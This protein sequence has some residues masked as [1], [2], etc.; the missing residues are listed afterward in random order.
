MHQLTWKLCALSSWAPHSSPLRH[1]WCWLRSHTWLIPSPATGYPRKPP[2]REKGLVWLLMTGHSCLASLLWVWS[3]AEHQGSACR[4]EQRSSPQSLEDRRW[5]ALGNHNPQ[6]PTA[7][8][9]HFNSGALVSQSPLHSATRWGPRLPHRNL[10][11]DCNQTT[12]EVLCMHK[13]M[14][15]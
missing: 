3:R 11:R 1:W 5:R 4:V 10:W 8:S 14:L 6:C 2:S 9:C 12:V 13:R 7:C 15:C